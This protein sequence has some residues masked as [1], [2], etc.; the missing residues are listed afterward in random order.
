MYKVLHINDS[1][2][3]GGAEAVFRD[4]IK[5]SQELGIEY[6]VIISEGKRSFFTYIYSIKEYKKSKKNTIV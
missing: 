5:V 4:T 6:D 2:E 1:W 3:G